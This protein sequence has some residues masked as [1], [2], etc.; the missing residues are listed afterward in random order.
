M[1]T[2]RVVVGGGIRLTQSLSLSL[3]VCLCVCGLLHLERLE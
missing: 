1:Y 3:C 2:Q